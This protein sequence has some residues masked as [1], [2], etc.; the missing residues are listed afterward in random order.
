[1]TMA[2][3][4][5]VDVSLA[6]R[7]HCVTRCV[8]RAF[9]L[10]EGGQ[11]RKEWLESRLEELADIFAV[12]VGGFS[13]LDNHLHVL[14]R[15]DPDV[16]EAWSD[17][18]VVRRWG[19]LFPPRDKSRRPI[20]VTEHWVRWRLSDAPWIATA[21][22]RLQ[23]LSWF[24]KCLKEPLSRLANRQDKTRGTFFEGRFKSVAV[25]DEEA[26]LAISVYIDLNPVAAQVATTPET[27]EYT[28]IKQRLEHV[29]AQDATARLEAAK[30]GSVAASRAAVGL[31]ETLWL[32]PIEDRRGL[33]STR[34]G[35]VQ[36]FSLGSYVQLVDYSGRLFRHGKASISAELAGIFERLGCSAQY[37][38]N[39]MEK[40][41]DGQLVGRFFATSRA[42]LREIAERFGMRRP[43]N[44]AGWPA[45]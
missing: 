36:G 26:L 6:R 42:K 3:A 12:A 40:L 20:P 21:R 16:A 13:V 30:E 25:C 2:R 35:M 8:R 38:Q 39:R 5:L 29:E 43:V 44:L 17:E 22:L 10:G 34:E 45:R 1:M 23:S 32:C 11:N 4:Q 7:Y 15:L 31:E 19:R 41:R 27:S 9:L 18:E 37:W 33:D 28:S 14:L 24:M